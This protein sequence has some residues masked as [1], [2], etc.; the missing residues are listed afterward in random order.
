MVGDGDA[1]GVTRQIMQHV[2]GAAEGRLGIDD[3][4]LLIKR[5]QEDGEVRFLMERHALAEEAQLIT[6]KEAPQSGDE[7]AAEDATEHL[8]RQEEVRGRRYPTCVIRR[9][10]A[11]RYDAVDVRMWSKCLSPGMKNRQE[12][13]LCAEM[14]RIGSDVEQRGRTGFE[15][16]GKE[17]PLVL[18]HQWNQCVRHAEDQVVVAHGQQL[19]LSLGQPLIACAGLALGAVPVAAGV[20][21]DDLMSAVGASIAM[22][23]EGSSATAHDGIEHLALRPGQRSAVSLLE[24]VASDANYI[25]HLEG[26][27]AHRFLSSCPARSAIC[28]SG[29]MAAW[30]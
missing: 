6:G 1:M 9:Q 21:R 4:V 14:L 27:P 2:L 16:Q 24:A 20:I 13:Q 11:T 5:V 3:P 12:P 8:D 17:L 28:S 26:R 10:S 22:T 30:R 25:G 15:Q 18:P 23:A 7:L 29:L 19:L